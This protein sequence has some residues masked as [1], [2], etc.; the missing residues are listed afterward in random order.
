[1][2]GRE[3]RAGEGTGGEGRIGQGE[4]GRPVECNVGQGKAV[5]ERVGEGMEEG[6][7]DGEGRV[8]VGGKEGREVGGGTGRGRGQGQGRENS[9]GKTWQKGEETE[10][11]AVQESYG[12]DRIGHGR[13]GLVMQCS[14][15]AGENRVEQGISNL[16]WCCRYSGD[17][18]SVSFLK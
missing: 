6:R 11:K 5:E 9:A 3:G 14:V 4:G 15:V 1:M 10:G 13:R 12:Q 7:Q 17:L 18:K 16:P 8:Q 2:Q